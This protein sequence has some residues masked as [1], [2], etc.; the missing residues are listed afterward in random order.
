MPPIARFGPYRVF[1]FSNEGREPPHIH[2]QRDSSLAKFWLEAW[3]E[4][5]GRTDSPE[6]A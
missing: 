1:F 3:Y 4:F 2:A 6:G 5:F